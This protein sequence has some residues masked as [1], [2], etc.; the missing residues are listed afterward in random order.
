[1]KINIKSN[2]DQE[3]ASTHNLS[4]TDE[5]GK[6][7]NGIKSMILEFVPNSIILAHI[8]VYVNPESIEAQGILSVDS[9]IEAAEFYKLKLI[10]AEDPEEEK[11]DEC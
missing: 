8:D 7:I 10:P 1:M 9:L 2:S 11:A 5:S 3:F 4:V 6:E